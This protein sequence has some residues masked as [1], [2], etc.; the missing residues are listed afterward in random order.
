M[1]LKAG[2]I[3][4]MLEG[5]NI[6]SQEKTTMPTAYYIAKNLKMIK[7]EAQV[8]DESRQKLIQEF[9]EKND[10]GSLK[11]NEESGVKIDDKR[12]AL[13]NEEYNKLFNSIINLNVSPISLSSLEQLSLPINVIESLLPIIND[14]IVINTNETQAATAVLD[15]NGKLLEIQ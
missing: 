11:I 10:D 9:G 8:I 4:N 12:L 3:Y 7:E 15:E 14:D 2:E 5:I 6:L 1:Q 13:F